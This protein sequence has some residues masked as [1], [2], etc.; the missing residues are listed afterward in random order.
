VREAEK[1]RVSGRTSDFG[2]I[3]AAS[4]RQVHESHRY[5]GSESHDNFRFVDC[6]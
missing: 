3:C 5:D 1:L 6:H 4:V 2:Q